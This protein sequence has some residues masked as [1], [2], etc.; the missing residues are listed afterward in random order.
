MPLNMRCQICIIIEIGS[1]EQNSSGSVIFPPF[2]VSLTA[3]KLCTIRKALTASVIAPHLF[4][5]PDPA[6][7]QWEGWDDTDRKL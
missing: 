5:L 7:G 3:I 1:N 4:R 2:P 6:A